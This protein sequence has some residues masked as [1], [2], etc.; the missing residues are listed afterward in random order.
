MGVELCNALGIDPS[1]V[2]AVDIHV[3]YRDV[4]SITVT[5]IM[6]DEQGKRIVK[7]LTKKERYVVK[8]S[9]EPDTGSNSN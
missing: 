7:L 3:G 9:R 1:H 4:V 8:E 5:S 6:T 2:T